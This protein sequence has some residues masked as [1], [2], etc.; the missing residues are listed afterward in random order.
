[1]FDCRKKSMKCLRHCSAF[2]KERGWNQRERE[3]E[4]ENVCVSNGWMVGRDGGNP[5]EKGGERN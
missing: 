5:E 1:M 3:R 2:E 4:R